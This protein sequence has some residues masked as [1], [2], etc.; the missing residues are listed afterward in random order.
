MNFYFEADT[1]EG[2]ECGSV[3]AS[4]LTEAQVKAEAKL[5]GSNPD[6]RVSEVHFEMTDPIDVDLGTFEAREM[7][8]NRAANDPYRYAQFQPKKG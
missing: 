2:V 8:R 6:L 7:V 5:L 1:N 3:N 4:D